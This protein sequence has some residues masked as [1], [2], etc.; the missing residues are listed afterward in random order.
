MDK[1]LNTLKS[2]ANES[3]VE[4]KLIQLIQGESN[5][6]S[7]VKHPE[8]TYADQV[9][10]DGRYYNYALVARKN[11]SGII[12]CYD[13]ITRMIGDK[14]E[15]SLG[16]LLADDTFE[17]NA[18]IVVTDDE[19]VI[20][21]NVNELQGLTI[22]QCPITNVSEQDELWND[23]DLFQISNNGQTWYGRHSL[24]RN[25]YLYVFYGEK[26]VFANRINYVLV[27]LAGYIVFCVILAS[28]KERNRK[29]ELKRMEKEYHLVSTIA[30]IYAANLLI[31]IEDDSWEPIVETDR[32]KGIISEIKP[33]HEM[34]HVFKEKCVQP[35]Y[36]AGFE[37][38]V[39]L[40]IL[41]ERL[42]GK[43]FIGYSFESDS[44]RSYQTLLIPQRNGE[45]DLQA[46]MI[47]FRNVTEQKKKEM[48]YQKMLRTTAVEAERANA[49][50]TDFLRRMSHDIRTPINGIRG[51]VNI[52]RSCENDAAKTEECYGKIMEASDFLLDL[53][54]NVL[55]MSKLETGE[56]ELEEKSFD[57]REIMKE[58]TNMVQAQALQRGIRLEK[59]PL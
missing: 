15:F 47:V 43:N 42:K 59:D 4:E 44:G 53:V 48:E 19:R 3:V 41:D 58:S 24:Y 51:M 33:A 34:L 30:S 39:N 28:F 46:V 21:T 36:Q 54:N 38:F 56:I 57:L 6:A 9:E 29:R 37:S 14:S 12:V 1:K 26:E 23:K 55:D 22:D 25:Y 20:G 52:G 32:L 5:A 8:K 50:K 2:T 31:H 7:I 49:V 27:A 18:R 35:Q 13:D 45:G 11:N 17:D 16:S 40:E 10:V